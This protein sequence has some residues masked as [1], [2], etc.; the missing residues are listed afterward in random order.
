MGSYINYNIQKFQILVYLVLILSIWFSGIFS[1]LFLLS[2]ILLPFSLFLLKVD[3]KND[4]L[5]VPNFTSF[6]RTKIHIS[7]IKSVSHKRMVHFRKR[8]QANHM[9]YFDLNDGRKIQVGLLV[10][11][12]TFDKIISELKV[13]VSSIEELPEYNEFKQ[14]MTGSKKTDLKVFM[15]LLGLPVVAMLGAGFYYQEQIAFIV[16]GVFFVFATI[17]YLIMH[18]RMMKKEN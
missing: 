14:T 18:K 7:Q 8:F 17:I 12:K 16:A 1:I 3:I 15:F 6:K 4:Y 5:V 9:L 2:L 11:Q 13:S 10:P